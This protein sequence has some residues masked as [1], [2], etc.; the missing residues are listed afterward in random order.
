VSIDIPLLV[1][2]EC[3]LCMLAKKES[4]PVKLGEVERNGP[5]KDM[6]LLSAWHSQLLRVMGAFGIGK[7]AGCG[8]RSDGRCGL[9]TWKGQFSPMFG[10][11][12]GN[13]NWIIK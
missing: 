1:A 4:C 9:M 7:R 11:R 5:V 8:E 6:N 13:W 10:N 3:R 12:K 2:L